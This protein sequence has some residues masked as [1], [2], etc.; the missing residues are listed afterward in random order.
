MKRVTAL[1][2]VCLL[3]LGAVAAF[4]EGNISSY[5]FRLRFSLQ[6]EAFPFRER[7]HIEGYA[8]LLDMMELRG[9]MSRNPDTNSAEVQLDAVPLTNPDAAVKIRLFGTSDVVRIVSPLLGDVPLSYQPRGFM[10]FAR[11]AWEAFR[12]P[13]PHLGLLIPDTWVY[14]FGDLVTTWNTRVGPV[15][16]SRTLSWDLV[17]KLADTWRIQLL[18]GE[19]MKIWLSSMTYP[20]PD[21][22]PVET[23]FLELP[24]LF[25]SAARKN[26]MK[27]QVEKKK[28]DGLENKTLRLMN[29][30]NDVIFEEH[31]AEGAYD[32]ALTV[33]EAGTEYI[34]SFTYRSTEQDGKISLSFRGDWVRSEAAKATAESEGRE[35]WPET[36]VKV[37][38][39]AENL[40]AAYP[41]DA[42]FTASVSVEGYLFP[43]FSL[44]LSGSTKANGEISLA[45]TQA[46]RAE[47]GPVF[48]CNGTVVPAERTEE[49]AYK[50]EEIAAKYNL[51]GLDEQSLSALVREVDRSLFDG[52]INFLY[53]LPAA[54]CQSI[55][56]DLEEYG[57]VQTLLK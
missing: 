49:L 31:S 27:I 14:T 37:R 56:D 34:P 36:M 4:G 26:A 33:P 35:G 28:T 20:L 11:R 51:F 15:E 8:Q 42:E 9:N 30:R 19:D 10:S 48:F 24:E 47:A 46:D 57:L 1:L 29:A 41:A 5:D 13:L 3:T 16:K 39:E 22:L 32:C 38:L 53:E 44:L 50:S 40:P 54:A 17:S 52:L 55:M 12:L 6:S 2:L 21:P 18:G 7:E 45:V 25:R 23:A 43:N